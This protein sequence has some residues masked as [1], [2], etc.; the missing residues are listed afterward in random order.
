MAVRNWLE[1]GSSDCLT[2]KHP[3][4]HLD[5]QTSDLKSIDL[6][7]TLFTVYCLLLCVWRMY[8]TNEQLL[9]FLYVMEHGTNLTLLD[10]S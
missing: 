8:G 5:T 1:A 7:V 10:H 4:C 3:S 6:I 2:N 9:D